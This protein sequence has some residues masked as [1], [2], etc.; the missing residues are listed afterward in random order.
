[1]KEKDLGHIL[2]QKILCSLQIKYYSA[3]PWL[4][5][6]YQV[7]IKGRYKVRSE[8]FVDVGTTLQYHLA[9]NLQTPVELSTAKRTCP[10]RLDVTRWVSPENQLWLMKTLEMASPSK[11][12]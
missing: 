10:S 7:M 8:A 2:Y 1:M 3:L 6:R 5:F 9:S 4:N 11:A 12:A